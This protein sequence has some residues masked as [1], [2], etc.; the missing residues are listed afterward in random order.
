MH[1]LHKEFNFYIISNSICSILWLLW[2]YIISECTSVLKPHRV[3]N[4]TAPDVEV[5]ISHMSHPTAADDSRKYSWE[6]VEDPGQTSADSWPIMRKCV[7][8]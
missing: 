1:K 8:R 4:L 3:E 6:M 5:I 2:R 7:A